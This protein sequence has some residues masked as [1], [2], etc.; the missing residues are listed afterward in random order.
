MTI[1]QMIDAVE[2]V[3][4]YGAGREGRAIIAALR[5]AEQMRDQ[6]RDWNYDQENEATEAWDTATK[7]DV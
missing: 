5:A 7:G 3:I 6:I 1:D 2:S 4:G